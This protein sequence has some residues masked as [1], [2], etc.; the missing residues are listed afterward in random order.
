MKGWIFGCAAAAAALAGPAAQAQETAAAIPRA[1]QYAEVVGWP[2]F[3]GVW[4]PDWAIL[5][6]RAGRRPATPVLTPAA[7]AT[8][9]AFHERRPG[10]SRR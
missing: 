5:F 10:P 2:D 6:G 9:D 4:S 7:Q 3:T 8:L 1:A